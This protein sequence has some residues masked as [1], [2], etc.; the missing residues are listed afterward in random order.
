MNAKELR[1]WVIEHDAWS[2][3]IEAF[4]YCFNNYMIE[5]KDEFTEYFGEFDKSKLTLWQK[6]V[7]L[8]VRN[9]DKTDQEYWS[10]FDDEYNENYEFI[11]MLIVLD[12][13][14]KHNIG[15][16]VLRFNVNGESFDDIFKMEWKDW[17]ITIEKQV[18]K[19]RD[20]EIIKT[21]LAHGLD[22]EMISKVTGVSQ[23]DIKRIR[24]QK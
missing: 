10:R 9:W 3:T 8:A 14:D 22:I 4:W 12:Y 19:E 17:Y 16:Y 1:Q 5:E 23:E 11:D 20:A 13:G 2:K 15:E 18:R 24:E 6:G 21:S 7:S